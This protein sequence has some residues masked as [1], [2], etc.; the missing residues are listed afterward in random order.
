MS[1]RQPNPFPRGCFIAAVSTCLALPSCGGGGSASGG[2]RTELPSYGEKQCERYGQIELPGRYTVQNNV[3]NDDAGN[4]IQCVSALWDGGS[5]AGLLLDPVNVAVSGD[6]PASYPAIVYG[7]LWGGGFHGGYRSARTIESISAAPSTWAFSVPAEARYD[8]A[9]DLWID[10]EPDPPDP[11]SGLEIMIWAS[12]RDAR[13]NGSFVGAVTIAGA[14]WELWYGPMAS[15][16][17]ATYR[18]V[19]NADAVDLDLVPFLADATAR[20]YADRAWYLL[21]V[22]AGFEIWRAS[23]PF[24]VSS[25]SVDIH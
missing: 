12:C 24:V 25:Y 13:P 8:A 17:T 7:W 6:T 9:Y 19:S 1:D 2:T 5:R 3:W 21:S 11:S 16:N 4:P 18:R 20:G 10:A 23:A 14:D 22:Q 15:Y